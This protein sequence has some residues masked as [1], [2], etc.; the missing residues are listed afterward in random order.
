MDINEELTQMDRPLARC[1][2]PFHSSFF[3]TYL[4]IMKYDTGF[5]V[6]S[7]IREHQTDMTR[8]HKT[9]QPGDAIALAPRI[10][11]R[12]GFL[13]LFSNGMRLI[14]E[15]ASYLDG[16]GRADSKAL[17]RLGS[18][19]YASESM[20]LTTR[21]MQ[22]A[23]WLLLQRAINDGEMSDGK[24]REEKAKVRLG[25]LH[26][27]RTGSGWDELPD[28]LKDLIDRSVRLEERVRHLDIG[29][30][31]ESFGRQSQ[32]GQAGADNTLADQMA[33][34]SAAFKS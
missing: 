29:M 18:V 27:S 26:P 16:P 1:V 6:D 30:G 33:R 34:L 20:R 2:W 12:E 17:S 25:G 11:E 32:V 5:P 4:R 19:A 14:E 13:A 15:T 31:G 10:A 7:T 9:P 21:L 22:I 3:D 28:E 23:S 8:N 24:G